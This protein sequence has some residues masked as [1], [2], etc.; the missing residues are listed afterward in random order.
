MRHFSQCEIDDCVE[1]LKAGRTIEE[2]AGQLRIDAD[3]L[4]M[5]IGL[6][7]SKSLQGDKPLVDRPH[8]ERPF[9]LM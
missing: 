5:L 7:R 1:A 2:L 4:K 3:S 9:D 8:T 6:N